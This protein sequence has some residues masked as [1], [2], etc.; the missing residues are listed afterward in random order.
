VPGNAQQAGEIGQRDV[1]SDAPRRRTGNGGR[2]GGSAVL[3]SGGHDKS[4]FHDMEG[5][6]IRPRT[7][8][9]RFMPMINYALRP[10]SAA[11]RYGV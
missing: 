8:G 10:A 4:D 3:R 2:E 1:V 9:V 6:H 5:N 11:W 7:K